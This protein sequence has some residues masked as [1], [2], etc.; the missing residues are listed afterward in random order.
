[1][2]AGI[3]PLSALLVHAQ[4]TLGLSQEALGKILGGVTRRTIWR[5]QGGRG[6]PLASDL[7]ALARSVYPRDAAL[8][9]EL[10]TYS[11]ATLESLGL[12]PAA[13]AAPAPPA[14][15][16]PPAAPAVDDKQT[17]LFADA[18]VCAAAEALDV[19]PRAVRGVLHAAF[20]R[21]RETGLPI[22]VLERALAP[23]RAGPAPA[24]GAGAGSKKDQKM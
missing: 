12:V 4:H 20:A 19:S 5:Y 9:S 16:A 10:A 7:H 8:A 11:G 22:D 17:R 23:A 3:R 18:V 1:M 15:P 14:P 21:A 2:A 24:K 6:R 13:P